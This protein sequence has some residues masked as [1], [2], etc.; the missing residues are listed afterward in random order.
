MG[1][2]SFKRIEGG[3]SH[4]K[5]VQDLGQ[6]SLFEHESGSYIRWYVRTK[7]NP[8]MANI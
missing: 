2:V 1:G 4:G 5:L 6:H 7:K 3:Q 8:Q